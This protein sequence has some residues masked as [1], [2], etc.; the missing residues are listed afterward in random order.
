MCG[1]VAITLSIVHF[2]VSRCRVVPA[3]T[4]AFALTRGSS[5]EEMRIGAKPPI[6]VQRVMIS[7]QQPHCMKIQAASGFF[8]YFDSEIT[9][10]PWWPALG[11]SLKPQSAG[12]RSAFGVS[13]RCGC[14]RPRTLESSASRPGKN[15]SQLCTSA[16]WPEC[17]ISNWPSQVDAVELGGDILS[18][19]WYHCSPSTPCASLP[20][21]FLSLVKTE[22]P[23]PQTAWVQSHSSE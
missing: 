21:N 9:E 6:S 2:T 12:A 23:W 11:F 3:V 13:G 1:S 15:S 19:S 22:P 4:L 8:E 7:L 17:I 5:N 16:T 18:S 14:Q 10:P 20:A